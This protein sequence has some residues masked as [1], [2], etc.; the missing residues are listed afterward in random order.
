[1]GRPKRT[2][3]QCQTYAR[4]RGGECLA[5]EYVNEDVRLLW[6]CDREH[7]WSATPASVVRQQSWCKRCADKA[8]ATKR[9]G[10]TLDDCHALAGSKG[11]LC[12][13]M[14]YTSARTKIPWKCSCGYVWQATYSAIL[15]GTWCLPCANV[16]K[17]KQNHLGIEKMHGFAAIQHGKC[18]SQSYDNVSSLL[19]WEC[20]EG[21]HFSMRASNVIAGH[22]CRQCGKGLSERLCRAI[23][24]HLYNAE[25]PRLRPKWLISAAGA[26]MELDGYNENLALAMEYQGV[27]HYK[28]VLKFKSDSNRVAEIQERDRLK[29][30]ICTARGITLLKIPYTIAHGHLEEFIRKELRQCGQALARWDQIPDLELRQ[31]RV[32]VDDRL[33]AVKEEGQRKNIECITKSYLGHKTPLQWR[34]RVCSNEF[35][36]RP[37]RL[38][39]VA[40][41]CSYCRKAKNRHISDQETLSK[42]RALLTSRGERLLSSQ[43]TGHDNP[44]VI[45]CDQ[46]HEWKTSWASL[47]Q[48]TR[49]NYCRAKLFKKPPR[50]LLNTN[51][52]GR[53]GRV[54]KICKTC[55]VLFEVRK[56]AVATAQY[57]SRRCMYLRNAALTTRNC[58]VCGEEFRSPPS[59]THVLTCSPE[60]GYVIRDTHDERIACKC[61]FCGKIFL[62]S[63]SRASRR[64]YCSRP[65][66]FASR[67]YK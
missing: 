30:S 25:F 34:C 9:V 20:S 15:R 43:F 49:C 16:R 1:M 50:K 24:E 14:E 44:L 26:R 28:P 65:C 45:L 13:A 8:S 36:F 33:A 42:I 38:A 6:R 35:S 61:R 66:M 12:L 17:R 22:W 4:T 47:R 27:Q 57:C 67:R 48:G 31:L 40:S 41:P 55:G 56:S 32:R 3:E 19:E 2:L 21:H 10:H 46:E 54:G 5:S 11:G 37:D 7:T 29:E 59:Q 52:D 51:G 58:A 23:L 62:E 18:L 63:P 53:A 64:R 39:K 60:C